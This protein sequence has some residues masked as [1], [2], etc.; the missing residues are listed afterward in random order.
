MECAAIQY[1]LLV[2]IGLEKAESQQ[3]KGDLD[4]N[5]VLLSQLGGR[6]YS[7]KE[8]FG[9]YGYIEFDPDTDLDPDVDFND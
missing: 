5:A 3:R 9:E 2:R 1:V 8:G 7:L 6:G 4:R